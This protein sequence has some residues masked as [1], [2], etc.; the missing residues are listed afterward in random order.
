MLIL[1]KGCKY[2]EENEQEKPE[3]DVWIRET[4]AA[5]RS[6]I[7]QTVLSKWVKRGIL[8]SKAD[9]VDKRLTLINYTQLER[10]LRER[11]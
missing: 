5:R 11:K 6:G 10:I 9:I 2:L 3:V 1:I 8:E 7:H 4:E